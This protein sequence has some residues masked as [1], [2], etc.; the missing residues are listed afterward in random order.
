MSLVNFSKPKYEDCYYRMLKPHE[1]MLGMAFESDYVI[2]G[3]GRDQ[4]KQCGNAVTPPVM[5]WIIEKCIEV[6]K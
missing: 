4:V 3:S 1:I 6:L 5:K 2:L